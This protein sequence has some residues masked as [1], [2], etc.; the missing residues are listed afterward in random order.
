MNQ[1]LQLYNWSKEMAVGRRRYQRETWEKVHHMPVVGH[2]RRWR[3]ERAS[4]L[5]GWSQ[6]TLIE[7]KK[8]QVRRRRKQ[9]AGAWL[10]KLPFLA[11][12]ALCAEHLWG[13][14]IPTRTY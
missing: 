6:E 12:G 7:D 8:G 11:V 2:S 5:R 4:V 3:V 1:S 10:R 9:L 13:T 14:D